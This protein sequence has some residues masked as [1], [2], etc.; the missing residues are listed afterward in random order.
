MIA[1]IKAGF[2]GIS[3]N[4]FILKVRYI[5][6][7]IVTSGNFPALPHPVAEIESDTNTL[8]TLQGQVA[9]GNRTVTATRDDM[10]ATLRRKMTANAAYVNSV[11]MGNPSMLETSG[12]EFV[13]DR[14]P[15]GAPGDIAKI[16]CKAIPPAG[17]VRVNWSASK[18]RDYYILEKRIGELGTWEEATIATKTN[19]TETGLTYKQEVYFRVAAVNAAGMSQWSEVAKVV[20]A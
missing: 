10:E 2:S 7:M 4:D 12:F 11:A 3:V 9:A 20:V 1:K 8:A 15:H 16:S 6:S 14:M 13:K 5:I 19:H 18:D 17:T